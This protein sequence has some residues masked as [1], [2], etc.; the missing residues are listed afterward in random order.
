MGGAETAELVFEATAPH[1]K[2]KNH[3]IPTYS[4]IP[5]IRGIRWNKKG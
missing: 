4:L 5:K 1:Q 3:L 2:K